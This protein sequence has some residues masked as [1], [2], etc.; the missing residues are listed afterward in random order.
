[1]KA[2]LGW[3][4][5]YDRPWN[6]R[7]AMLDAMVGRVYCRCPK[8]KGTMLPDRVAHLQHVVDEHPEAFR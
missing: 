8:H 7:L 4:A 1:M 6:A 3:F 5:C 2:V